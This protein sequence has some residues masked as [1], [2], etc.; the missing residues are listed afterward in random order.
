MGCNE[1]IRYIRV[2]LYY[3]Y[4]VIN[5]IKNNCGD[6]ES[7]SPNMSYCIMTCVLQSNSR[8]DISENHVHNP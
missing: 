7:I 2:P 4:F 8:I 6:Y 3:V 1:K 5:Y